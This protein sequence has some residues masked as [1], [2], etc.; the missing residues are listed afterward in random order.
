MYTVTTS[1]ANSVI[2]FVFNKTGKPSEQGTGSMDTRDL[3][4]AF[5]DVEFLDKDRRSISK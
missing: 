3:A 4:V 2:R 5:D 1:Q